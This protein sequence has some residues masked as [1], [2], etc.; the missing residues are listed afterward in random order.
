MFTSTP[1]AVHLDTEGLV[2]A[3]YPILR[4]A[5]IGGQK[6]VFYRKSGPISF[7]FD[8][9]LPPRRDPESCATDCG[10]A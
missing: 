2:I 6:P 3:S 4:D 5:T 1:S 7:D 8:T 10:S 9:N